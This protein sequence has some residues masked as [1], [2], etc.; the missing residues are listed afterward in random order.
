[1]CWIL[2]AAA[3]NLT[4][5]W[6]VIL[7]HNMI[8]FELVLTS[9]PLIVLECFKEGKG[10]EPLPILLI[11]LGQSMYLLISQFFCAGFANDLTFFVSVLMP[12]DFAV[13]VISLMLNGHCLS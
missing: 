8:T 3:V 2:I 7:A 12:F 13:K 5:L 11:T 4:F 9:F 10:K 6:Q 1:M